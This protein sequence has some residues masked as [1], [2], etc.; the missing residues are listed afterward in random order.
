[1][2][3]WAEFNIPSG[4]EPQ[5]LTPKEMA[6]AGHMGGTWQYSVNSTIG[7]LLNSWNPIIWYAVFV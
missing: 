7:P 3:R 5:L 1:M 2:S 4:R 6:P